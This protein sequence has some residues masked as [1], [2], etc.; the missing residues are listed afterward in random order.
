M[1]AVIDDAAR[2]R[3]GSGLVE[4]QTEARVR[5]PAHPARVDAVPSRLAVDDAAER[6][7]RQPRYPGD[8]AAEPGEEAADVQLA[9]ADPDLEKPRLFEP[10]VGRWREAHQRFA[11]S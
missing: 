4:H 8:A 3:L 1:L 9:A 2:P 10:L 6:S 5:D 7:F 11:E